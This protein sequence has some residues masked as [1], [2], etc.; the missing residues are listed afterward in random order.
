MTYPAALYTRP[1][2]PTHTYVHGPPHSHSPRSDHSRIRLQRPLGT[3][4]ISV[5]CSLVAPWTVSTTFP[6]P[7]GYCD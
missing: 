4:A 1:F 6:S 3:I 7:R 2:I 5:T